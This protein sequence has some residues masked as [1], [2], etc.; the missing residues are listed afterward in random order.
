MIRFYLL[1]IV[2]L[3]SLLAFLKAPEYHLWLL[4]IVVTEFPLIFF[5]ISLVLTLTGFWAHK[6]QM[7]GTVLGVVTMLIFLSPIVRAWWVAKD[8]KKNM[9]Q[10]FNADPNFDSSFS[11]FRLF[12]VTKAVS[13]KTF[14]YVKYND[15]TLKLDFYPAQSADGDFLLNR[16]CVIVVHGGSWAGGDSRQLPELNSYLALKG[17]NVAAINYR[18]APKWQTPAPVEDI[19]AAIAYLKTHADELHIDTKNFVLLGRSAGAQIATLAAYT[20]NEPS[21]KG[22]ID[23]YGPEDMVWGYSIP[24]NPLIMDSRKV[25]EDYIGGTYSKVPQK[26]FACSPLEFV[27]KKSPPTLVIHGSNDVLV[28][29]E[30]SRRLN[31]K[32]QQNGIKHYWLKLPWATH[33]FDY[34]LNGPGGQLSTFAVATFLKTVCPQ[35][36]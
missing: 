17:Y 4:A 14:D 15:T 30:H 36:P 32:L 7:A 35:T 19:Q 16:P 26:Y 3:I 20:I 12:N 21:L 9:E 34:N 5:G 10:A 8:L 18:M 27:S 29:P 1:I 6:Y 13:Y 23:F 24:S 11:F 28:S 25:M 31:L 2:S 22:V 33:G